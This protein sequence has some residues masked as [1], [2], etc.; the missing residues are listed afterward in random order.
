MTAALSHDCEAEL[1][2]L[3][4]FFAD[5]SYIST[6]IK[7]GV[8]KEEMA[9]LFFPV[10]CKVQ[11]LV[12]TAQNLQCT[13]EIR[14]V[15]DTTIHISFDGLRTFL[16]G[17]VQNPDDV[18]RL[19]IEKYESLLRLA[20]SFRRAGLDESEIAAIIKLLIAYYEKDLFE[21]KIFLQKFIN[22]AFRE[23]SQYYKSTYN[24]YSER[25]GMLVALMSEFHS[26]MHAFGEVLVI[27]SLYGYKTFV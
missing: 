17:R 24:E 5:F 27:L 12:A 21:D 6:F 14:C 3:R 16:L 10:W 20:R 1:L 18:A 8:T 13:D 26:V 9:R 25:L 15:D 22:R 11:E 7:K 4:D 2:V 23:L 19:C